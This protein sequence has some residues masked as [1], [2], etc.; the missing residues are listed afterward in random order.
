M[1]N[2]KLGVIVGL[3]P[4][5]EEEFKKLKDLG[6][7]TAQVSCWTMEYFNEEM[8]LHLKKAAR[9][10]DIEI[11]TMWTGLPGTP[12]WN[13]IQG[14]LTIGLV[15]LETR[16]ARAKALKKGSDF[17]KKVEVESVTTHVGFIPENPN[18]PHYIT[19][20]PTLK[21]VISYIGKNGQ[22]FWFETGQETPVTLL[23]T[24]QDVGLENIGVNFDAGNLILYGKANPVDALD[25]IGKYVRGV[26]AKDGEYPRDGYHLGQEKPLGEGKVNYKVF[27]PKLVSL[28]YKGAITIE[29]EISG[30]QQIQ[31][32]LRAKKILEE[33]LKTC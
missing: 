9:D 31:D 32:I 33:I 12:I 14:P 15:P 26:H 18:D 21:D 7:P 20:I 3:R 16:E 29:R 10:Y 1:A 30:P 13:F 2:L 5:M 19:L 11:T 8:A 28:G 27:I 22:S 24:I 17:A 25:V 23:R 6:F 4:N